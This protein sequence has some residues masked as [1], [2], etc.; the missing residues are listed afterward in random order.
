MTQVKILV[1]EDE[2]SL[3]EI[4]SNDL[5]K[6]NYKVDVSCDGLDD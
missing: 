2:Q 4:I 3:L 5:V 6:S 1:V